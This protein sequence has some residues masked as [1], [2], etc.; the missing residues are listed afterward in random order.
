MV[1][2][3][4]FSGTTTQSKHFLNNIGNYNTCLQ[5]TSFAAKNEITDNYMPTFKIQV[6]STTKQA[7]CYH[8][9]ILNTFLEI[10]KVRFINVVE[11][12]EPQNE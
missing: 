1:L 3:L 7:L 2:F 6:K 11:L 8:F 9:W 10:Y 5:M 12:I 4:L